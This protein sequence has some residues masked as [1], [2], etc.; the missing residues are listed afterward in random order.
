M[1]RPRKG[2]TLPAPFS[3]PSF[4]HTLCGQTKMCDSTVVKWVLGVQ[5]NENYARSLVAACAGLGVLPPV[6]ASCPPPFGVAEAPA[7]SLRVVS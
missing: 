6:G 5:I 1:S 2:P 7:K 4:R 3:D